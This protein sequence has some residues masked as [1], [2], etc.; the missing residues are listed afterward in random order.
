MRLQVLALVLALTAP[1]VHA[2][3]LQQGDLVGMSGFGGLVK[4]DPTSGD[5]E[6]FSGC[7]D[8]G[9]SNWIGSGPNWGTSVANL[10]IGLDGTVWVHTGL[11]CLYSVDP[12]TGDRTGISSRDL[13]SC[14]F[15][16]RGTG[17][18]ANITGGFAI[19]PAM[20]ASASAIGALGSV[21]LGGVLALLIVRELRQRFRRA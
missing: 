15:G 13:A 17:P 19:A 1:T 20:P 8:H 16:P 21:A 10:A 11:G 9:C 4:L 2:V 14:G 3:E 5:G 7:L 12:S 18:G 6:T